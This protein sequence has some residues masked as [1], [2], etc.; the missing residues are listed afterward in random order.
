MFVVPVAGVGSWS[1]WS[2]RRL[3]EHGEPEDQSSQAPSVAD[4]DISD[5]SL[6]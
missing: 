4:G 1:W 6:D 5:R 3:S 2:S